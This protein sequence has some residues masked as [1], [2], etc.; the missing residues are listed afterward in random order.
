MVRQS[1]RREAHVTPLHPGL[2]QRI[3]EAPYRT[4]LHEQRDGRRLISGTPFDRQHRQ[5][6]SLPEV[7]ACST[8]MAVETTLCNQVTPSVTATRSPKGSCSPL[9]YCTTQL[10]A[11][12]ARWCHGLLH[13]CI[14]L[15]PAV[16]LLYHR[17]PIPVP[18]LNL[19][20]RCAFPELGG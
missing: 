3:S 18:P 9:G 15:L 16:S 11:L 8:S 19:Q 13:P 6:R 20:S 1:R 17:H 10:S 4:V 7:T 12:A 14:S 5:D 2:R